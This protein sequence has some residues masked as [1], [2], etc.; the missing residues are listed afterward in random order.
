MV[1]AKRQSFRIWA[2]DPKRIELLS[3][4]RIP[5]VQIVA[6]AIEEMVA[7]VMHLWELMEE[8]YRQ[9]TEEGKTEADFE[10]L[11]FILD[12]F[13]EFNRRVIQWWARVKRPGM[14]SQC[15]ALEAF[16]SVVR[17]GR[18]AGIRLAIGMQ[19]GDARF[20]GDS[21]EARDNFDTRLSLG[22]LSPDGSRMMWGSM[23]G[24]SLPGI[25][26]RA[27]ANDPDGD[28]WEV[29][30]YWTPDP[31]RVDPTNPDHVDDLAILERLMPAE[32]TFEPLAITI[33][34]PDYDDKGRAMVW[35]A[36]ENSTLQPAD[37]V[38][39]TANEDQYLAYPV[40]DQTETEDDIDRDYQRPQPVQSGDIDVGD[41]IEVNNRWVVVDDTEVNEYD[42]D[43]VVLSWRSIEIDT[44]EAGV[45]ICTPDEVLSCRRP[46]D[47]PDDEDLADEIDDSGSSGPDNTG[48]IWGAN[49]KAR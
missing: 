41:L 39:P 12:E 43:S 45:Q 47:E 7:L 46:I 25:R 20:F 6:T 30:T 31:R 10:M 44:D 14:P 4:R 27:I 2:C 13:A 38:T 49:G 36:I 35:E 42:N 3:L 17:L 9:I 16:A 15:P 40:E 19:R 48:R 37:E 5:N 21:A 34:E 28:V 24:T 33:P 32:A 26:G 11:I 29:Q 22:R 8:R 1:L 23:V 18:A